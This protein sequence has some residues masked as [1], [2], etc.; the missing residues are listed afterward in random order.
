[1]K[2]TNIS[3]SLSWLEVSRENILNNIRV[4]RKK[5][6]SD[7]KIAAVVKANAY[8]HGYHEIAKI[9]E[10]ETIAFLAVHSL[11]EAFTLNEG[12]FSPEILIV[13]YVPFEQ[14]QEAVEAGFHLTV[15]N[16]ETIEFLERLKTSKKAKIHLK[17]ETGTNR[18]GIDE[19]DLPKFTELLKKTTNIELVGAS[20]HFANIEDT[21]DHSYAQSQIDR[22][23]Q[24]ISEIEDA[25]FEIPI[26][27]T[28]SSA[29]SLLFS[30]THYNMIRFGISLYG[31]WPSKETYLS[32]RLA[33]GENN[34]LTPALTWKT[35]VAQIKHVPKGSFI[36]YGCTYRTTADSKIAVLPLGYYDGYDRKLSNLG[37]VL[38]KGERAQ[39]RGRVCMDNIMV[40]VTSIPDVKVEDEV[41]LLGGQNGDIIT[42]EQMASW[43][44]TINYEIVARINPLLPR[45]IV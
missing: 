41:V 15:Y 27:H 21:T 1:M 40:D 12:K 45:K 34:L 35:K 7:V 9:L 31:L 3:T 38:I 42:A 28:A 25:G 43:A 37:Y 11:E 2:N 26:K 22:Y 20:T 10:D 33:G 23:K 39:V 13:G 19:K 36:G 6:G 4:I 8:G 5:I 44:Q 16:T 18:Q 17:L 32:Y 29:A 14:L 24:I 30:K